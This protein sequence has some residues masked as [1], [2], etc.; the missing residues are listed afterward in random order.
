MAFDY[1][2]VCGTI[3][4]LLGV[5]SFA[6]ARVEKRSAR[7]GV[8]VLLAGVVLLGWAWVLSGGTLTVKS[9]PEAVYR[10]IAAWT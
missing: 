4:V 10:L 3:L 9:L 7:V 8:I 6:N 5:V 2:L 1:Q